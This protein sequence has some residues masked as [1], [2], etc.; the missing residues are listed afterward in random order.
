M[1]TEWQNL[2]ALGIVLTA[3]VY[4]IRRAWRTFVKKRAGG[5]GA[6]GSCPASSTNPAGKSLVQLETFAKPRTRQHD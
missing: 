6:C 5:C 1:T 4:L 3:A 2:V